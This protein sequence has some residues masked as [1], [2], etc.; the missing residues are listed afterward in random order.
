MAQAKHKELREKHEKD[1][2]ALQEELADRT[3]A[4]AELKKKIIDL[5]AD[6]EAEKAD[7]EKQSVFHSL[8]STYV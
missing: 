5:E 3:A 2:R 6:L 7:N 1:I 4:D 8:A